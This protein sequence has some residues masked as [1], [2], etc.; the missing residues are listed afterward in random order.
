M[1]TADEQLKNEG[2]TITVERLL[3]QCTLAGNALVTYNGAT[4]FQRQI[5]QTTL[6][7]ARPACYS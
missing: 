6:D 2:I 4:A 1:H 3:A 7:V 5:W